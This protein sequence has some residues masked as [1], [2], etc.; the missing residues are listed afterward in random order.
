MIR[1][2]KPQENGPMMIQAQ[3]PPAPSADIA[4]PRT[5]AKVFYLGMW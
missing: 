5:L 4:E 2:W 3:L 1:G